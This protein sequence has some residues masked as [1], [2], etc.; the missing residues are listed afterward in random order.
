MLNGLENSPV[1]NGESKATRT[2]LHGPPP[3]LEK[4]KFVSTNLMRS[5]TSCVDQDTRHLH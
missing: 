4:R 2:G 1:D 5:A 3:Y